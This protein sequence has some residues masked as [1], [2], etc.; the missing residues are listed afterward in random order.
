MRALGIGISDFKEIITEN[1]FYVDKTK[2]IE[3][4]VKDG[5]KV[6]LVTRPRRFG[7]TLNMSMLKYFYDIEER[8]ENS[9]LFA[10]LYIEKSDVISE[11]GKYPVIFLSMKDI[12]AD[13]LEEMKS[14]LITL[15][16]DLYNDFKFL[17][18][19]LNESDLI[20]FD[21]IWL[22]QNSINLGKSLVNLCK[23]SLIH[24]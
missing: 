8:E 13:N 16:R 6:Q 1:C 18:E 15:M 4:L 10:G 3:E 11:Q 14:A 23:L 21:E 24:I 20:E 17:R 9:K 2:L 12:K 7:K 22:K 5:A 19:S